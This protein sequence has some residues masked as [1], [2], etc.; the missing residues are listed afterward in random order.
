MEVLSIFQV[1]VTTPLPPDAADIWALKTIFSE[2]PQAIVPKLPGFIEIAIPASCNGVPVA[3]GVREPVGEPTAGTVLVASDAVGVSAPDRVGV[4]PH[5]L[6]FK[7]TSVTN[8]NSR[9][10]R[11]SILSPRFRRFTLL[12]SWQRLTTGHD[13]SA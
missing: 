4:G 13:V 6:T 7:P 10:E 11:R 3:F 8:K 2:V 12:T 9:I 5:A 1:Y